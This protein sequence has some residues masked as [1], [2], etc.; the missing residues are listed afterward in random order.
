M[1]KFSAM[2]ESEG[3]S[4]SQ[5]LSI[6][7]R[8][9]ADLSPGARRALI[10]LDS[11]KPEE[12]DFMARLLGRAALKARERVII[13]REQKDYQPVTNTPLDTEEAIEAEAVAAMRS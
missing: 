1:E 3:R 6:A 4:S 8:L 13:S 11:A 10:A 2:L 12:R 5:L 9:L 7:A